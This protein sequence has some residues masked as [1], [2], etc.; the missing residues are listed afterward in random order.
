MQTHADEY[1]QKWARLIVEALVY[2]GVRYF[3]TAPGSRNAPLILAASK[4]ARA[5]TFIHFDERALCFHALGFA[6][7]TQLPAA[8]IVTSGTAVGNLLPGIMEAHHS[9]LP[10]ILLTADRPP[11]LRG[12]D[13]N[14]TTDQVKIFQ[15][16][17]RWQKDCPCPDTHISFSFISSTVAHAVA[18]ARGINAG[19]VH[20]NCM[21]RKPLFEHRFT[22]KSEKGSRIHISQGNLCLSD[23]QIRQLSDILFEHE[24]GVIL[25][26]NLGSSPSLHSLFTLSK[27]LKWPLFP[28]ILS[29][30]RPHPELGE[31]VS[32]HDL[33]LR[34]VS[35]HED[36]LPDAVL[37][38]GHRFVSQ[39]LVDWIAYKKPKC[40]IHITSHHHF[41]HS[42]HSITHR[43]IANPQDVIDSLA[44]HLPDRSKS[45]WLDRWR[46]LNAIVGEILVHFFRDKKELSE[47]ALFHHLPSWLRPD[48]SLFIGNSL[49]IRAANTFFSPKKNI[50][51]IFGN[52]GLS[53]IDGNIATAA[54]LAKGLGSPLLAIIGDLT[55]L[56]DV[57]S[58][59]QCKGMPCP[60]TVLVINNDGGG[61]FSFLPIDPNK[62]DHRS[63]FAT[64]HGLDL[65]HA[66]SFFRLSYE[67]ARSLGHI[68]KVLNKTRTRPTM[69]E[70]HTNR[71]EN[72]S[73]H[74]EIFARV[75]ERL[76]L[77]N[78]LDA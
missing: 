36:L 14:Q 28:D 33:I 59:S 21:F 57:T 22:H 4:H 12:T 29:P 48:T 56:H 19:P 26:G 40:H 1:N 50:G 49:P 54:G 72:F 20:L 17:V 43:W 31:M 18:H 9:H 75:K 3:C 51:P 42:S 55:C 44:K 60:M 37:Q 25:V 65:A 27:C 46:E 39:G 38:V 23:E 77:V 15:S 35:I 66:A 34:G 8:V 52:R 70:M 5:D 62:K 7:A 74:K 63:F 69:I 58:F 67:K 64:P 16:F 2:Q 41:A 10:M 76:G 24:R 61:I 45:E 47:P 53:G 30:L 73:L 13:A 6:K 71:E 78:S 32:Y 11:E 68:K